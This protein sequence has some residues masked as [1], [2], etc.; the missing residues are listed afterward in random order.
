MC[1]T[2][3]L[4]SSPHQGTDRVEGAAEGVE[5]EAEDLEGH[6]AEQGF[7]IP[8]LAEDDRCVAL[9]LGERDPTL[10]DGA[11]DGGP[12]SEREVHFA[13][14]READRLPDRL[15]KERVDRSTVDQEAHGR[16]MPAWTANGALDVADAHA[17]EYGDVCWRAAVSK[18]CRG[19][20]IRASP[21]GVSGP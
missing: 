7:G 13:L 18:D 6:D 4:A 8:G 19:E 12:V 17:P 11:A 3:G 2:S 1:G 10:R 14:G 9:A 21:M 15:G 20:Q 5:D 16:F